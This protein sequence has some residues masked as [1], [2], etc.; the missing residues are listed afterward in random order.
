MEKILIVEDD[1][2]INGGIKTYLRSKGYEC[3]SVYDLA[4]AREAVCDSFNLIILDI[5]LPD[6]NGLDFCRYIRRE[7]KVPII[8][9]T[10]NDTDE[11]VIEGF[12]Q[13]CDDYIAKPFSPEVLWQRIIAVLRRSSSEEKSQ[14]YSYKDLSADF[15]KMKVYIKGEPVKL[16]KTEFKLLELLIKNRGQVLT[17]DVI[18]SRIWDVDENFIDESTLSVH[19]RRLRQKLENDAKNPE[20]I[21]TVF[22]IGYTFGK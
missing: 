1:K 10:A 11:D 4:S 5:K 20:Y 19:I 15:E 22:G 16:S 13:G 3:V 17:R 9:L 8:F 21:I 6:G 14:L 2:L 7:S 12:R 18:L